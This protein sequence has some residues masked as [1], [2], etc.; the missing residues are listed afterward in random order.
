MVR[1]YNHGINVNS[2]LRP[3]LPATVNTNIECIAE[4]LARRPNIIIVR[5]E[6]IAIEI[7]GPAIRAKLRDAWFLD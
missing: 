6:K 4:H 7:F 1:N 3:K 5:A 2:T